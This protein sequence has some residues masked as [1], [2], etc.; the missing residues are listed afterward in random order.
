MFIF[1][2]GNSG[3]PSGTNAVMQRIGLTFKGL[4]QAGCNPLIISKHSLY[5]S[6]NH[7][8]ISRYQGIPYIYT[9]V[10]ID[11]PD[12]FVARNLNK[13]SGY[14]GELVLLIR[15]RKS[16]Q[17][18]IFSGPSMVELVYYRVL[19]KVLKF[20]LIVQYVELVSEIQNRKKKIAYLNGKFFDNY[21]FN[22]CD[23]IITISE[24]LRLRALSRK[25][26]L[27]IIKIPA[28]CDFDEFGR[29]GNVVQG[30]F[31]MYCGSVGYIPVIEFIIDVY[32]QLREFNHY[33]GRLLLAI[34]VGDKTSGPYAV[35][36]EKIR[37]SG[38]G[39]SI[40]LEVNV[41]HP[42]LIEIYL[43]AELLI[44]PLRDVVQDIAGFHHK[45]GEYCAAQKPIISTN[46]GEM[47]YYFKDGVSAILADDYS[48]GSYVKKLSEVLPAKDKL[49][50][51]AEAGYRVGIEKL[52]YSTYGADLKFFI[53]SL[54]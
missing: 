37:N 41:P 29:A 11:R 9:S 52:N 44:V 33:R 30:D 24:F 19:S 3:F 28:I 13:I 5:K 2:L 18:A 53:S 47:Q 20:K 35:L 51:I 10:L 8:R 45:V 7:R 15:K 43:S 16:M 22:F 40:V 1:H 32:C 14:V 21:C 50:S 4:K 38:F 12:N 26:S 23:G 31:L 42:K 54:H 17:A 6:D 34:G 48:V 25:K 27:P 36:I 46:R 49:K 39:D